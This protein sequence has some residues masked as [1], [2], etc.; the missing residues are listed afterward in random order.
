MKSKDESDSQKRSVIF[1]K[2]TL[3]VVEKLAAKKKVYASKII[4]EYV[5]KGVTIDGY[6][7]LIREIVRDELKDVLELR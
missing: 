1:K 5:E 2:E 3:Q 6:K 4:M 7:D